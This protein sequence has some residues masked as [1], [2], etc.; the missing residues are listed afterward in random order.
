ML[1]LCHFSASV[2]QCFVLP[3]LELLLVS[4]NPKQTDLLMCQ[5]RVDVQ[6]APSISTAVSKVDN[7]LEILTFKPTFTFMCLEE[8]GDFKICIFMTTGQ[9]HLLRKIM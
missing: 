4:D 5:C 2:S 7:E 3:V 8:N 1:S 9:L 6:I